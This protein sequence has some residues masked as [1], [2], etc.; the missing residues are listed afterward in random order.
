[1]V[2]QINKDGLLQ[3]YQKASTQLHSSRIEMLELIEVILKEKK[4]FKLIDEQPLVSHNGNTFPVE[5]VTK[6][7]VFGMETNGVNYSAPLDEIDTDVLEQIITILF[8]KL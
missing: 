6:K 8:D 5:K 3:R 7:S 1:M 4:S 2:K